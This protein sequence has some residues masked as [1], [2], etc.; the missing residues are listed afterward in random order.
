MKTTYRFRRAALFLGFFWIFVL[1]S[2]LVHCIE[3]NE[4]GTF[5]LTRDE[6]VKIRV[7]LK[8]REL[9]KEELDKAMESKKEIISSYDETVTYLHK[10]EAALIEQENKALGY[11]RQRN[12]LI[13]VAVTEAVFAGLLILFMNLFL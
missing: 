3:Q 4:D 13:W 9:Y 7:K 11:L 1:T 6:M 12:T 8:E 10:V 2:T 5:S